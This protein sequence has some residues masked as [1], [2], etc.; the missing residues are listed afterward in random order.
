MLD[1]LPVDVWFDGRVVTGSRS[2]L[3]RDDVLADEGLQSVYRFSIYVR[4]GDFRTAPTVKD[5]VEIDAVTYRVL[6]AEIDAASTLLRL[7]LGEEYAG[8]YAPGMFA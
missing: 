8:T 4:A 7:D 3:R 2:T 6:R 5:T 1:D